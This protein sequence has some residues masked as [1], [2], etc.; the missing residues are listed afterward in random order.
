MK[1][2]FPPLKKDKGHDRG[3]PI[4]SSSVDNGIET[5]SR[6]IGPIALLLG[7]VGVYALARYFFL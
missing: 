1:H 4:E 2:V 7:Y 6:A 5:V 3:F